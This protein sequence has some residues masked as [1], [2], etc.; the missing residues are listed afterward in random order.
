MVKLVKDSSAPQDLRLKAAE[1]LGW[2]TLSFYRQQVYD[3]L[4]GYRADDPAVA[5]EVRR[6]LRRL[7]DNAHTK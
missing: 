7:E 1:A 5:D 2:Y 6:T 4:R 3:D